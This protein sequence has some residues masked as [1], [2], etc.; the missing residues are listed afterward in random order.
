MTERKDSLQKTIKDGN[1]IWQS[2]H[3]S[4]LTILA[5]AGT[6]ILAELRKTDPDIIRGICA[7][8]GVSAGFLESQAIDL[9]LVGDREAKSITRER[10]ATWGNCIGWLLDCGETDPEKAAQAAK[11]A[12]GI[13]AVAELYKNR[14]DRRSPED[15]A[16]AKASAAKAQ[17][18]KSARGQRSR[19]GSSH[20]AGQTQPDAMSGKPGL[21]LPHEDDEP[22]LATE[23][24]EIM[25]TEGISWQSALALQVGRRG[26]V[27]I[28]LVAYP[29][30]D[31]P[32]VWIKP[33]TENNEAY[34]LAEIIMD[35]QRERHTGQAAE[36]VKELAEAG[37]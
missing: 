23:I 37:A 2:W 10:R 21:T 24:A 9:M 29:A 7:D 4:K 30:E 26:S 34:S 13:D 16:A 27:C 32:K 25:E 11:D 3:G 8:L 28:A 17:Q 6:P 35:A 1:A 36:D 31:E 20:P 22:T 19:A 15:I 5:K 18:T 12:G 14:P 33:V